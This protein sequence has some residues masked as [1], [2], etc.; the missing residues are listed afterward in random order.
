MTQEPPKVTRK[1][2]LDL[3][4]A[5]ATH[6]VRV[7]AVIY[8]AVILVVLAAFVVYGLITKL[9]GAADPV[10][11]SAATPAAPAL[12]G[13]PPKRLADLRPEGAELLSAAS[14]GP[15]LTLAFRLADGGDMIVLINL[16]TGARRQLPLP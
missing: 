8:M 9:T 2:G 14:D 5:A 7:R 4:A 13:I 1:P 3:T 12:A 11:R 15:I 6:P 16:E 10:A